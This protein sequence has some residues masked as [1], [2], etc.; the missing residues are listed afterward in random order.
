MRL[1]ER[2]HY[3]VTHPAAN[4]RAKTVSGKETERPECTLSLRQ[5]LPVGLAVTTIWAH[6]SQASDDHTEVVTP[7]GT[8]A[9]ASSPLASNTSCE[10]VSRQEKWC[11]QSSSLS[12]NTNPNSSSMPSVSSTQSSE[13]RPRPSLSREVSSASACTRATVTRTRSV[14]NFFKLTTTSSCVIRGI[15]TYVL[16]QRSIAQ[17]SHHCDSSSTSP[18]SPAVMASINAM[19]G[20]Q[21]RQTPQRSWTSA[22]GTPGQCACRYCAARWPSCA[23]GVQRYTLPTPCPASACTKR[24]SPL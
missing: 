24:R 23:V 4:I 14:S 6:H 7:G 21:A 10:R 12:S 19:R 5:A 11:I 1:P 13:S 15:L 17:A 20:A 16:G 9:H 2:T 3:C 8:L 18:G 22:R